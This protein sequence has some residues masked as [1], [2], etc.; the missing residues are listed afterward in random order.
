[1]RLRASTSAGT[2]AVVSQLPVHPLDGHKLL[3]GLVWRASGSES[4]A[5]SLVRRAGKAWLGVEALGCLVLL[6]EKPALGGM[7]LAFGA[8]VY[9]QRHLGSRRRSGQ[10]PA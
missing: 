9:A 5:R 10:R 4:R 8:A 3:V 7:A 1:M 2:I 6:V